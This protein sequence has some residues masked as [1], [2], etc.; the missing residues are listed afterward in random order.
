[1]A[2]STPGVYVVEKSLFPPSVAPVA[3]AIPAFIG[4][5]EM[6]MEYLADDLLNKSKKIGSMKEYERFYGF[7][8]PITVNSVDIGIDNNVLSADITQQYMLYEALRMFFEN[9]GGD[10]YIIS[11]GKYLP[12]PAFAKAD[13]SR[14][15]DVLRKVDEPTLIVFPDA[16][17]LTQLS[18]FYSLQQEALAQC[19]ELKD[20]FAILDLQNY[21]NPNLYNDKT[22]FDKS[23][24]E[25]RDFIGMSDLKYGAA[26]TPWINADITKDLMY[27]DIRTSLRRNGANITL[28]TLTATLPP[29]DQLTVNGIIDSYDMLIDDEAQIQLQANAHFAP[30]VNLKSSYLMLVDNFKKEAFTLPPN[31]VLVRGAFID[32]MDHCFMLVDL[33]DDLLFV[34]PP[35]ILDTP[36]LTARID[37]L[38]TSL[39]PALTALVVINNTIAANDLVLSDA[40]PSV[41]DYP[42][43]TLITHAEFTNPVPPS[44]WTNT[45][46]RA[47][48]TS[49]AVDGTFAKFRHN[50]TTIGAAP[51]ADQDRLRIENMLHVEKEISSIFNQ[52]YNAY[53]GIISY[54]GDKYVSLENQ[55][56][57]A[58]PVYRNIMNV[59]NNTPTRLPPSSSVAG[60]YAYVDRNRGVWKAPANV[61][62]RS[63]KG[64]LYEVEDKEQD[65]LNIDVNSG[66]S[67]NVIRTFS[68]KGTMIWGARTLAGN[69]NEWRYVSVRRFFNM[70][71]ESCKKSTSWAVFEPNDAG[72]WVKVKGMIDNFL[73]LQW[74]AGA[75]QGAKPEEAFYVKVGLGETMTSLDVLEGRMNVEIGMAVV[76]PAEFI[77]LTFSHKLATS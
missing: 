19:G 11:V 60:R 72:T 37:E 5:T 66:K 33:M 68:G 71:E 25:F 28:K 14:G 31:T 53:D 50:P 49:A 44:S 26:Y 45:A 54:I 6:A 67:I 69:D 64:A 52:F 74:R 32:M 65:V 59:V 23:N 63:V 62:L 2:Y 29:A 16:V 15:L 77:I 17:N 56:L 18:G 8:A 58:Y 7:G 10:C 4:Y 51:A 3:T 27:R 35:P 36:D 12:T 41:T 30:G 22:N 34:V 1:M 76:R 75:L 24:Q 9:G 40:V 48:A 73:I 39:G 42:R 38:A 13:F 57:T 47:A 70:V 21:L 61:D 20:R 55:L 46:L 43:Q